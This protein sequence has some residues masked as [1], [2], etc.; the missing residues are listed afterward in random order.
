MA[1]ELNNN[2]I[3][4]ADSFRA[5]SSLYR[6]APFWA[7]NGDLEKEEL[8]RQIDVFDEMGIGGYHIHSRTGLNT[9]YLSDE[10]MELVKAC[11]D[12]GRDK[13][14]LTWLYDEDRWPS[15]AAGGLVT[16]D[17]HYRQR[18]LLF[19]SKPYSNEPSGGGDGDSSAAGAR[20]G[21]GE[22]LATYAIRL[23]DHCLA[24][25]RLLATGQAA[26]SDETLWYAYLEVETE[27]AWFNA[28][29]YVDTLNPEA[30][31]RFIEVTHE[32]YKE[33]VGDSFGTDV[34]AIFT[35][36]PQFTHKQSLRFADSHQDA[37]FPWTPDLEAAFTAE[38]GD[39]ML[40]HFPE[41]IWD[42]PESQPS[43]WRYRYH[44][45]I[46]ERFAASFADQIGE[47]CEANGIALTGHMMSEAT[48]ASQTGALGDAMRSY[49]SMQ[50]PGIDM[51]CDAME[52]NTAK[53]A[54]SAARQ[55]GNPGVLSELYG[56]TGWHFDFKGHK[57][58]GDWQAALGV[59]FRVHHLSWYCMRG[60]A[61]RDYPA[62]ISYQS[63]WY[64]EYKTIEDHFARVGAV[65][66][67]G[68]AVCRVGVIHPVESYWLSAGP[69][70]TSEA[71]C[72]KR[73]DNFTNLT[74]WLLQG[75]IDFDF[76]AESLLP[77]QASTASGTRF[78]VG[79]MTYE[80]VVVPGML[81]M[82]STTLDRLETFA[83]AG[84]RVLF[85]GE[86]PSL[87]DA[88]PSTRV[89]DLA[90]RCERVAFERT[91]LLNALAAHRDVSFADG[92]ANRPSCLLYQMREEGDQRYLFVCNTNKEMFG[93][94]VRNGAL[95]LT[96]EYK[97]TALNTSDG[98][99]REIAAEYA[100]G[101][102]TVGVHL[103]ATEHLLL[104]LSPGRRTEGGS[105]RA[106]PVTEVARVSSPVAVTLDEPN[107][108]LFD[109]ACFSINGGAWQPET[110]L[111]EVENVLRT[112]LGMAQKQGHIVQPWVDQT[113]A[114][115]LAT[116]SLKV[117][118]ESRVDCRA[119]QLALENVDESQVL[120]DGVPVEM[121]AT[122]FFTDKAVG[123]MALPDI[124]AG[125]H[126]I[127]I[128]LS[129][130]KKTSIE[131]FYLLG[132]F[133]VTL[134]GLHGVLTEPV[135]RLSFGDWTAQGL[136]FY[137]GNVTY[138]CVAPVD[139]SS[140]QMP[141]FK[142]TTITVA[143]QGES[144][145]IF[146]PP[147]MADVAVKAGAPLDI[148]LFGHRANCFGPVHLAESGMDWLGPNSYRMKG[149]L[150]SPEYQLQPLGIVS[151][152]I[153]FEREV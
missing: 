99:D 103:Y 2:N 81:T 55:F 42:L 150:F 78:G 56:V 122:G 109:K 118:V 60:E 95:T 31:Q 108:L 100:D 143:S 70:D 57:R 75:T 131:W 11:R 3:P 9:E 26:E 61:K 15:G 138:H 1:F 97:V 51:L 113:P 127:E 66:S 40:A 105:L 129:F 117:E 136:P 46:A 14:M 67:R 128:T 146:H 112:A 68:K 25:A 54:Q 149:S 50:I 91:D 18:H 20:E 53:Q 62:S 35:D 24:G 130:T 47:W 132:D 21:N 151:A 94:V 89:V 45:W 153:V 37:I 98:S 72:A 125:T 96:G 59:L 41:V 32:R 49:R 152:P 145:A 71:A 13:K 34:P 85:A 141:Q 48:L 43:V 74:D 121:N 114:V 28:Q 7:W 44:E 16:K 133:G 107:V 29:T 83:K 148:T 79:E 92:Q 73:E 135:R 119:P 102:T 87:V 120:L 90:E 17:A 65:L 58:Q 39:S 124:A 137:G 147:Y 69:R 36:E 30:M 19:T 27:S 80:V 23:Q 139:G 64:K 111:L 101:N 84:G 38:C 82:R 116:I 86:I 134:Q 10:F 63:P 12:H 4:F 115:E 88:V 8:L 110:P 142:A 144:A 104:R 93:G 52:L 77:D 123:T 126:T 5:P 33:V 106:A 140:I 6:G 22:L 76:V